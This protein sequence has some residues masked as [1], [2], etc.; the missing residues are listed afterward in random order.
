MYKICLLTSKVRTAWEGL[1]P[2]LRSQISQELGT[3]PKQDRRYPKARK[4]IR[5]KIGPKNRRCHHEYRRLP[6]AW[7]V[8][9]TVN[10]GTH[11]IEIEYIGKHP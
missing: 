11:E 8:F 3:Y 2:N 4:H 6:D 1:P 10:D 5:A 7:R 9:Y